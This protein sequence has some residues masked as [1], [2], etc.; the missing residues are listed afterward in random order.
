MRDG[1]ELGADLYT[2][3]ET[4]KALLL[5]RGPYGRGAVIGMTAGRQFAARGYTLLFV[6]TRGTKNN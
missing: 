5:A 6:S 2:P 3:V 1:I 4:S